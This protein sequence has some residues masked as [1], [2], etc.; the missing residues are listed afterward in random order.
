MLRMFTTTRISH[1]GLTGK[2]RLKAL[3]LQTVQQRDGGY[4]CVS[5]TAGFVFVLAENAGHHK[6]QFFAG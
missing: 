1:A 3:A 5:F 2:E 6:K 4:I